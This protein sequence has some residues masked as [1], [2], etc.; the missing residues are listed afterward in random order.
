M[1][2]RFKVGDEVVVSKRNING[3]NY[4]IAGTKGTIIQIS[5]EMTPYK[6][7][8]ENDEEGWV[9]S[10][11]LISNHKPKEPTH[12]VVWEEDTDPCE[13]FISEKEA[14]GFIKVLSEKSSVKKESIVLVEIK[15]CKKVTI[16]KSLDYKQHKI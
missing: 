11:E 3:A 7:K 1:T 13:F 16:R 8:F 4:F 12:L 6:L 5:G 14:K 9:D 10:I 2:N 15:S